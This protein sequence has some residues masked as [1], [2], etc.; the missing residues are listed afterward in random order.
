[1]QKHTS[2]SNPEVVKDFIA[3]QAHWSNAYKESVV[4]AYAHYVA[5]SRLYWK[6]PF[7]KRDER[8]P[9]V[10]TTE[11]VN[12]II[13]HAGKKYQLIFSILRDTGLRPVEL[14]RLTLRNLDLDRGLILPN[15]AKGG[16]GR[17]LKLKSSTEAMLK[18]YL[19]RNNFNTSQRLFPSANQTTPSAFLGLP[20]LLVGLSLLGLGYRPITVASSR[21]KIIAG[22]V[23]AVLGGLIGLI[24]GIELVETANEENKFHGKAI[25]AIGVLALILYLSYY[26]L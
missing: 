18:E 8:I 13:A 11:Q 23:L 20:L 26:L 21:S 4:N 6:R 14:E 3:R 5:L 24:L 15:T 10:P 16:S 9:N 22:Y 12:K 2:I 7:Y 1:M 19:G 25:L 17:A